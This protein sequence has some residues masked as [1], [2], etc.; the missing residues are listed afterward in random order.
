MTSKAND[1]FYTDEKGG[2]EIRIENEMG[3]HNESMALVHHPMPTGFLE[4]AAYNQQ[5][6]FQ[7]PERGRF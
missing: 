7:V 1:H 5:K 6:R 4:L 2:R 3:A